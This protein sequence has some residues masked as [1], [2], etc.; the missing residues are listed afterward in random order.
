MWKRNL[1]SKQN[2]FNCKREEGNAHGPSCKPHIAYPLFLWT[3]SLHLHG[4]HI[5]IAVVVKPETVGLAA[6]PIHHSTLLRNGRAQHELE[7]R[8]N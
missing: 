1:Q 5:K 7:H 8:A 4:D 2:C 3:C 6:K